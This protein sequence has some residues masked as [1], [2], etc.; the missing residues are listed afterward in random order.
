MDLD[1]ARP[2]LPPPPPP[3]WDVE[4]F[5]RVLFGGGGAGAEE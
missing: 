5:V 1:G 4:E 2:P 3:R